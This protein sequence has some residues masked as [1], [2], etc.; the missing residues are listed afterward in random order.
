M[1]PESTWKSLHSPEKN[2]LSLHYER[3]LQKQPKEFMKAKSFAW[4]QRNRA[5]FSVIKNKTECRKTQKQAATEGIC[6]TQAREETKKSS[7][8]SVKRCC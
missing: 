4:F 7:K 1:F 5:S 8:Q 3:I 2:Q 6:S